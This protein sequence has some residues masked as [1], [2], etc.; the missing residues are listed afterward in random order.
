MNI[1]KEEIIC[2][3][4]DKVFDMEWS[5]TGIC[6]ECGQ[7]Y[8]FDECINIQLTEEQIKVLR[9]YYNDKKKNEN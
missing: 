6:P 8:T 9:Q 2:D 3:V 1:D 7:E 5:G 4:C